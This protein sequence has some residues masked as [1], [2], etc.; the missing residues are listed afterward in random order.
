MWPILIY[1]HILTAAAGISQLVKGGS[2]GLRDAV[3]FPTG[4][5]YFTLLQSVQKV[6]E[7]HLAQGTGV[8]RP[9]DKF[10][11]SQPS[12]AERNTYKATTAT[13]PLPA[14]NELG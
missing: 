13:T 11:Y 1:R 9:E 6:S 14:L 12:S 5:R 8:K 3:W 4:T 2:K 10:E 7:V